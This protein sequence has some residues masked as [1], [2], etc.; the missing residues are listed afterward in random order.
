MYFTRWSE[1]PLH[2]R[3][4][5]YLARRMRGQIALIVCKDGEDYGIATVAVEDVTLF[6]DEV[7]IKDWGENQGIEAALRECGVIG[8]P[9]RSVRTGYVSAH[10]CLLNRAALEMQKK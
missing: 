9:L 4:T 10:I 5:P 7:I 6:P 2:L 8:P 1:E 3:E